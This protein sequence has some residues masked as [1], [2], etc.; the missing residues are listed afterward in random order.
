MIMKLFDHVKIK[1]SGV[2]GIIVDVLNGHFTVEVDEERKPGD[3]SGYPGRWPLY[4]CSASE[5]ELPD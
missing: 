2:T 4:T 5:L 3:T 1:S